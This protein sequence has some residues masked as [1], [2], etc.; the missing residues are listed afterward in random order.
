MRA[1]SVPAGR[2]D[3]VKRRSWTDA[4]RPALAVSCRRFVVITRSARLAIL[5]V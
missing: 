1:E 3:T 2:T 5:T 4:L